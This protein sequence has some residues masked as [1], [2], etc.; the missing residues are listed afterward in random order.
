MVVVGNFGFEAGSTI[1]A[2]GG[3]SRRRQPEA[4]SNE[5]IKEP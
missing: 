1:S 2:N 4:K 3:I 5:G